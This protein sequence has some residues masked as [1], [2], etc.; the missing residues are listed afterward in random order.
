M[1]EEAKGEKQERIGTRTDWYN[2]SVK[3]WE[4]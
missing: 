1:E 4:D 3:Y 2:G